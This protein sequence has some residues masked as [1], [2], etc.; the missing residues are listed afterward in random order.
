MVIGCK[1]SKD[2]ESPLVDQIMYGSMIGSLLYLTASRLDILQVVCMVACYQANPKESHV[3]AVKRIFRYLR[4]T[5][6]HGLW[7]L[8]GSDFTLTAYSHGDWAGSVDDRKSTSGGAFY[9]GNNLVA[10]HSK[11]QESVSLSTAEVEY[12]VATLCRTQILWMLQMLKDLC[13]E[14]YLGR[15]LFLGS[16]G[17]GPLSHASWTAAG[18][19]EVGTLWGSPVVG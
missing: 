17:G 9:L 2:D 3:A 18:H 14:H 6:E 12:I 15:P 4:E 8:R 10:W 7:Y 19:S 13:V 16:F 1:F 11:K 5:M